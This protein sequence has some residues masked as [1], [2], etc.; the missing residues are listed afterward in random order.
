MDRSPVDTMIRQLR[1]AAATLL[2]PGRPSMMAGA[3]ARSL[4]TRALQ[5]A[6][7][8]APPISRG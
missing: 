1:Q 8:F 7:P 4:V 2:T 6:A 3:L 5:L